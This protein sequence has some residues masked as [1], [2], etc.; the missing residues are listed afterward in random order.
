MLRVV[1]PIVGLLFSYGTVLGLSKACEKEPDKEKKG[2][3]GCGV[4]CSLILAGIL[5]YYIVTV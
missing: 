5:L 2:I 3:M 4:L 1:L